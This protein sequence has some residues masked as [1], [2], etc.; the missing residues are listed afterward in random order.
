MNEQRLQLEINEVLKDYDVKGLEQKSPHL[1]S[2]ATALRM[3]SRAEVLGS[4]SAA[5]MH[6]CQSHEVEA[7]LRYYDSD[8]WIGAPQSL[9]YNMALLCD[10][11]TMA[12]GI[13]GKAG[14]YRENFTKL[15]LAKATL[16]LM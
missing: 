6:G 8:Y 9:P 14:S 5:L 3:P 10:F 1:Q 12:K 2:L 13:Y 4:L 7:V 15:A 11:T 16:M